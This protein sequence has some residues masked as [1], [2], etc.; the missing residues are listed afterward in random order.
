[1][2]TKK[3]KLYLIFFLFLSAKCFS[4]TTPSLINTNS[5]T[6]GSGSVAGYN[7][8]GTNLENIR[9]LGQNHVG[10]SVILWKSIPD[11]NSD[12]DGGW[13]SSYVTIDNTFTYRMS[14]WIK[15]TNSND[16]NT[17]FGCHSYSNSTN[18][19]LNLDG[20]INNNPYFFAGDLPE[21]N[22]WYLLIG[23]V[24]SSTSTSMINQGAIYDGETGE[25]VA[26]LPDF[27]FSSG[28]T[29]LMHRS[30]LYYDTNTNDTQYFY[31]PRI[32]DVNSFNPPSINDLLSIN[33]ESKLFFIYDVAGNQTERKYC[34][35]LNCSG[36]SSSSRNVQNKEDKNY[37]VDDVAKEENSNL[38]FINEIKLFPNPTESII[39]I[40]IPEEILKTVE[41]AK[42]YNINGALLKNLNLN[43]VDNSFNLSDYQS[44]TYLLHIHLNDG[45]TIT[46]KIIKK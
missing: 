41:F 3:Q 27:K 5:W 32:D 18:H 22:K 2:Y 33:T 44:G 39:T 20:T 25:Q 16:G 30:Y 40:S 14:I 10:E 12:Q 4:Q 8:N 45:K 11:S 43:Q 1:M 34:M 24:Q 35:D 17:Y 29:N 21:L 9:E 26:S 36:S 19:I 31:E 28:A 15:K 13:D 6:I 23:Y 46:K 37:D 7:Q 38:D 42:I